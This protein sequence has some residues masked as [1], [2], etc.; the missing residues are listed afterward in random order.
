MLTPSMFKASFPGRN[1][2]QNVA[3]EQALWGVLAMGREKERE[4][5]TT[6][7]EFECWEI[8][9]DVITLGT[10][11]IM[12]FFTFALISTLHLLAEIWRLSQQGATGEFKFQRHSCKL[13]Y[14]FLPCWQ[15]GP[16][17]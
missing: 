16:E 12:F 13:S 15:W 17:S 4:P 3:C 7:L 6:S 14:H 9:N 10:F 1:P 11:Q 8:S 2:V 5:A